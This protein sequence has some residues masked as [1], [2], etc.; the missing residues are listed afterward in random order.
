MSVRRL[1][2][3]LQR[4]RLGKVDRSVYGCVSPIWGVYVSAYYMKVVEIINSYN[5]SPVSCLY[6]GSPWSYGG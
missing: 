2:M 5:L 3:E 1:P 6:A 4:K